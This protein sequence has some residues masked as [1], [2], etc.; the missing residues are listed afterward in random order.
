VDNYYIIRDASNE[1]VSIVALGDE[2]FVT[3]YM[4][5]GAKGVVVRDDATA[6]KKI[7]ELMENDSCKVVIMSEELAIRLK[8]DREKWRK[9]AYPVFAILPG[10]EGARGERLSELYSLVSLAVGAKLKMSD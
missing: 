9:R 10:L 8:E 4:M 1:S 5:A 3:G 6:K 7:E 2:F